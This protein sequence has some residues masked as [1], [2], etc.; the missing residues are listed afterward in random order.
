M[1]MN[2]RWRMPHDS[3]VRTL[4]VADGL[5]DGVADSLLNA[6]LEA[7]FYDNARKTTP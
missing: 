4:G 1:I 2:H 3:N 7:S 6:F 5:H